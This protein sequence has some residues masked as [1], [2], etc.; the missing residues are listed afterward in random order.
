MGR[1]PGLPVRV[2]VLLDSHALLWFLRG[3]DDRFPSQMRELIEDP[4]TAVWVSV[5]SQWELMI[6]AL[7]RRL[8][9][10]DAPERFLVD[11][12]QEAGFRVLPIH[13]RHVAVLAE[14]PAIHSNPFDRMLIAQAL[15]ENLELVTGDDVLRGYPV[16][17]IW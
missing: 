16:R 13:E 14:L 15:V 8:R 1:V 17:T 11:L 9:L 4:T 12:P 6:K 10:P 2:K 7:G 3:D 5:A